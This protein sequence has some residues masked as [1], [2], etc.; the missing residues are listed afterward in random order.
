MREINPRKE[1]LFQLMAPAGHG[2]CCFWVV[3]RLKSGADV[4]K[5][6]AAH[7]LAVRKQNE[8]CR[9]E[10]QDKQTFQKHALP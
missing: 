4:T 3:M 2:F 10:A 1:G 7:L 6:L 5:R 9:G 8:T